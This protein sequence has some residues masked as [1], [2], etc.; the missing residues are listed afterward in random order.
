MKKPTLMVGAGAL[1]VL[2]VAVALSLRPGSAAV[3]A[4]QPAPVINPASTGPAVARLGNQLQEM[5]SH[6]KV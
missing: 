3:A 2:V 4:Q 5:V 1:A 6:F